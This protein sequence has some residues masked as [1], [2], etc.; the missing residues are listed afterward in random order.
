MG[1]HD[2]ST[3]IDEKQ[4]RDFMKSL[5]RDVRALEVMI[6]EGLIESGVRRI[7]AEQEMFLVDRALRPAGLALE[8]LDH[9]KSP[10]FTT[11]LAKFNLEANLLP[12]TFGGDCLSQMEKELKGLMDQAYQAADACGAGIVLTGI[13]PTLRMADLGLDSMV[14]NA[15]Y[16][17]LNRAMLKLR[18]GSFQFRIKGQDELDITHDNVMLESCNTSFQVHFQ[19]SH[20][21]FAHFYNIAQAITGPVMAA[22]V[23]SPLLLGK[24]LWRE[25]RVALFQ[26]SVDSRSQTHQARGLRPRVH[27]GDSWVKESVLEIFR[28]DIARFRVV[29]S[30]E[31]DEDP[32]AVLARGEV[33]KLTALRLHNGT[34]YRWNRACY[35]ISDGKA[36]LRIEN[37]VLPSGPTMADEIANS[38][39][40]FG[41]MSALAEEY[42]PIEKSMEFADAKDNFLRASR[43]GLDAQFN[44]VKGETWTAPAL[45][46]DH[47]LPLAREG[48]RA[49]AVDSG[50]IDRYL[51]IIEERVRS[52]RSG[53]QWAL[54]SFSKMGEAVSKD[55]RLRSLTRG[56]MERQKEGSP[57]HTWD[58]ATVS[59]SDDWRESYRIVGQFMTTDLFTVRPGDVVDLAASLMEWEHIRHVPVEDDHG[60]LVGLISH[61]SL[62]RMVGRG[63][64]GDAAGSVPV[65]EIMKKDPVTVTPETSTGDAIALM[66]SRQVGCLPVVSDGHLVGI[67]TDHDLIKV[68]AMLLEQ[69]LKAG[70]E[71]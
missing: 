29:L 70:E 52:R 63:D 51:G 61:R 11:E 39:F 12:H 46:L 35:G 9:L 8:M 6:D 27:F 26:Q 57:V 34:V 56:M 36:H 13:L 25:T 19:V 55:R 67:L 24:S 40:Y 62:L 31:A 18:G 17:A 66:R 32:E 3:D 5:L 20:D 42:G 49:S 2:V 47:L 21:E 44:W 64:S 53:A 68:A 37:R 15:R 28:E 30:T 23:N 59:D 41:L 65:Q 45:I 43:N 22:A 7:G 71:S 1:E 33:P 16:I 58:L 14:P 10:Q 54:E 48:L 4:I 60:Q 50:D 69:N 38:A